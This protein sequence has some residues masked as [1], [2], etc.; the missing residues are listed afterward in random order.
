MIPFFSQ[1]RENFFLK[2]KN[3][4]HFN[5]VFLSGKVLQG[6]SVVKLENTLSKIYKRKFSVCVGS[7]TDALYFSLMSLGIKPNDEVLVSNYSYIAS[8]S[9]IVRVGAKPLFVDI[10]LD[11]NMSLEYAEKFITKKTKALIYVHLF[12]KQGE[13]DKIK[14][15]CK[16]HQIHLIEDIAQTFGL[17][18]NKVKAG[19][20]GDVACVSFDPT[21]TISAPGSGGA[22]LTD[23]KKIYNYIKKIRYHGKNSITSNFE[24][25]GF[26]S[27]MPTLT[28]AILIEKLKHNDKW[29]LKRK[30]IAEYY[31]KNLKRDVLV[32]VVS[33]NHVFHKYVILTSKR[34]ELKKY[35][36]KNKIETMIHYSNLISQNKYLK[37][38]VKKNQTFKVANN[39]S[40]KVLSLPIHPFLEDK[41]VKKIV[42]TVNNFFK[43]ED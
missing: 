35:L 30:K 15:F 14:K 11:Y 4:Q 25:L 33:K 23:S 3:T 38:Y 21:K 5:K 13:L 34:N 29:I 6:P 28:A 9:A 17:A 41:E 27:Q 7:C 8:A 2:K 22:I 42:K 26:N 32:P 19:S 12:G 39:I 18:K 10:D 1:K 20:I 43:K 40:K 37:K 36:K 16:V 24:F 31:S